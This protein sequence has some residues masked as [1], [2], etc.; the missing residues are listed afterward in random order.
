MEIDQGT[1][2][3]FV[4]TVKGVLGHEAN[5]YH[6]VLA[7]KIAVKTGERYQDVTRLIRVKTSFLVLRAALLCLRGSR[8]L[9]NTTGEKCED[10]AFSL[11]ELGVR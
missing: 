10:Y 7:E 9:Y 2:T 11:S 6:K 5:L 1:F 8:T 3:P 4:V